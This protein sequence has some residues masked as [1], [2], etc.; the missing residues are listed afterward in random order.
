MF[1][2]FVLSVMKR[3]KVSLYVLSDVKNILCYCYLLRIVDQS[4]RSLCSSFISWT[5]ILF[6]DLRYNGLRRPLIF[7]NISK[8]FSRVQCALHTSLCDA[9]WGPQDQSTPSNAAVQPKLDLFKSHSISGYRPDLAWRS[10]SLDLK[11]SRR[12]TAEAEI[13]ATDECANNLFISITFY[14][15]SIS[16]KKS[17]L[18]LQKYIT[19]MLPASVE[20]KQ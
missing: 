11:T 2:P 8:S 18:A 10:D 12:G 4:I 15:T 17:C 19:T 3:V 16:W 20:H 13:Y 9:N 1:F 14:Q 6:N 7:D 5:Q